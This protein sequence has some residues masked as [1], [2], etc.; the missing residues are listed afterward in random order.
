MCFSSARLSAPGAA[1]P[2][3]TELR[4]NGPAACPGERVARGRFEELSP[5]V[6]L[7]LL[8]VAGVGFVLSLA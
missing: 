1:C 2:V 4:K 3:S 7:G 5:E 8:L 6:F